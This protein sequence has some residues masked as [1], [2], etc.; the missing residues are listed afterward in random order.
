MIEK[1]TIAPLYGYKKIVSNGH[2][3]I[4]SLL[5]PIGSSVHYV[6]GARDRNTEIGY[7]KYPEFF[8]NSSETSDG[9]GSMR[10]HLR[11]MRADKAEVLSVV[12][13][14]TLYPA[15]PTG[16]VVE[17]TGEFTD[18]PITNKFPL[19]YNK[20]RIKAVYQA[21]YMVYPDKFSLL[22]GTCRSGIH[23]FMSIDDA[24]TY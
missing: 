12:E 19:G 3:Y 5:I 20:K 23:F 6:K 24:L 16:N 13:I 14:K 22:D 2:A 4:V 8:K 21:E 10:S 15:T 18:E 11:K 9:Y 17:Y 7:E 1:V